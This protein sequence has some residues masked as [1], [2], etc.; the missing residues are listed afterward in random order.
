MLQKKLNNE[1]TIC[2]M[3]A[4]Q[5]EKIPQLAVAVSWPHEAWHLHME[6]PYVLINTTY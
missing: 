1:T 3:T 2:S 5:A 6:T 4:T